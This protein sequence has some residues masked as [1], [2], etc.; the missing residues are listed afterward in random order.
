MRCRKVPHSQQRAYTLHST[1][2]RQRHLTII[3]ILTFTGIST[4]VAFCTTPRSSTTPPIPQQPPTATSDPSGTSRV[5][6]QTVYSPGES[7]YTVEVLAV[8]RTVLPDTLRRIDSTRTTAV[9]TLLFKSTMPNEIEALVAFDSV[10]KVIPGNVSQSLPSQHFRF[11]LNV[12]TGGVAVSSNTGKTQ[13]DCS[14]ESFQS[15]FSG[16]EALPRIPAPLVPTSV[17]SSDFHSCRGGVALN[18]HRVSTHTLT[19]HDSGDQ[20]TRSTYVT[21]TG[22]GKQWDQPV[23]INGNGSATDTIWVTREPSRR[24][25]RVTGTSRLD[26]TFR[27]PLATQHFEQLASLLVLRRS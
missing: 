26:I 14:V 6:S 25:S 22:T 8:I 19:V 4:T 23:D 17:D 10:R 1:S 27:S 18:F 11:T 24:V 3:K 7:Q 20:I 16:T 12:T 5:S 13:V 21:V 2:R 9:A 15:P